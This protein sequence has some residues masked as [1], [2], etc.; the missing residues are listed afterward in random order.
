MRFENRVQ[1]R[2]FRLGRLEVIC[3][4][5][6]G[7]CGEKQLKVKGGMGNEPILEVGRCG[8]R[9]DRLSF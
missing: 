9:L 7:S 1:R 4:Q 2:I 3:Q 6:R 5:K 8:E